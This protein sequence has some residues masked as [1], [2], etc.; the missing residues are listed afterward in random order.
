MPP[1]AKWKKTDGF[2]R[3]TARMSTTKTG[4]LA[5]IRGQISA[6]FQN[7]GI[8]RAILRWAKGPAE[9][10]QP[11]EESPDGPE[12]E[13]KVVRKKSKRKAKA[14]TNKRRTVRS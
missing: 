7:L 10:D 4:T 12:V 3:E 5:T 14:R 2:R 13:E 1:A 8:V 11:L 9:N 6:W